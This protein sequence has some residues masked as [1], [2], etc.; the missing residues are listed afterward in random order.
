MSDV[1]PVLDQIN[2]VTSNFAE[3]VAFYRRLGVSIPDEGVFKSG[4]AP[5]H[6][7][8]VNEAGAHFDLDSTTFAQVWN[9]GWKG[10]EDLNGRV[11]MTFRFETR[12]GV[13]ARYD[14]LTRAGYRGLHAP[15]DAFWGV[16]FAVVEDPSGIAV[17]LMSPPQNALRS[18]PP[19]F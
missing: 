19:D 18:R 8:A 9:N 10:R 17:G 3:S 14:E 4:G 5:H 16:R 15:C 13:D 6:V 11:L 12:A 1:R 7:N 2:V